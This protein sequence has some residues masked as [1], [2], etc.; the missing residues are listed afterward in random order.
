MWSNGSM[1]NMSGGA[2]QAIACALAILLASLVPAGSALAWTSRFT[3][4]PGMA[5]ELAQSV[6]VFGKDDRTAVSKGTKSAARS[7]GLLFNNS[8]RKVCS[9]FCV[10][11][12]II[13]TA[14]HCLFPAAADE[15][16]L[17]I[18]DAW[19]TLDAPRH[20]IVTRLMGSANDL[21]AAHVVT[22]STRLSVRP[23]IDA[24]SDWALARLAEPV[25]RNRV[26]TILQ[27]NAGEII[28]AAGS[29]KITNVAF[30][31]DF[32][33][34]QP[35]ADRGCLVATGFEGADADRHRPR[36]R[37]CRP[38]DPASLRYRQCVV[39]LAAVDRH[40]P[41]LS[42]NRHQCR[43]LRAI[44][45]AGRQRQRSQASAAA[46]CCQHR[47]QCHPVRRRADGLCG[48]GGRRQLPRRLP[49]CSRTLRQPATIVPTSMATLAT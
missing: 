49:P 8:T 30:H 15:Q 1:R 12:D 29:G 25:C 4:W 28:A 22:G 40:R 33:N 9:A 44:A 31:R 21:A 26:L 16:P 35:A 6:A 19:F 41:G 23:P 43:N 11:A 37:P 10:G 48:C 13:A 24:A 32:G 2:H 39:G 34:W 18:D 27:L 3:D 5:G 14:A 7:V 47:C 46:D 42:G 45:G 38:A 17:S 36:L 20:R